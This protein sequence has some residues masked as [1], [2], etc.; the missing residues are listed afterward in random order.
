GAEANLEV[1]SKVDVDSNSADTAILVADA[2]TLEIV[3]NPVAFICLH[4]VPNAVAFICLPGVSR[5]V[6]S[7]LCT[8]VL[9]GRHASPL[10][11]F[12]G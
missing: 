4:A 12:A 5:C 3:T 11:A 9:L 10:V 2:T 8:L 7:S 6:L 1:D